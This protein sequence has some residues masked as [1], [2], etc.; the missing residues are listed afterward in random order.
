VPDA[1]ARFAPLESLLEQSDVVSLHLP[2]TPDTERMI[3][4]A[5]VRAMKKGAILI[6]TARGELVDQLALVDALRTGHVA[7]AG[8]DVFAREP[9][10]HDEVL[11]TMDNVVVTPHVAWLTTGTF[12]RSFSVAA[13]NCR[14]LEMGV[15]LLH[16]VA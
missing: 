2:L 4:C 1:V 9:V 11:L 5:A 13:E 8:L 14:R 16:R 10:A 15:E 3:D 12:D 7:G 6:N